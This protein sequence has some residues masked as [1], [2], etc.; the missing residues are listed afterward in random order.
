MKSTEETEKQEKWEIWVNEVNVHNYTLF[1]WIKLKCC[2]TPKL[3]PMGS[4]WS[5]AIEHKPAEQN[6]W[7]FGFNCH[8]VMGFFVLLTWVLFS[9]AGKINYH[10]FY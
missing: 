4:G 1:K 8:C 5:T 7:G 6:Y 3:A 9:Y 2:S 10:F